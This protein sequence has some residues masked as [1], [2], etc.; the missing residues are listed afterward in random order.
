MEEVN[1]IMQFMQI[2]AQLGPDGQTAI[3]TEKLVDYL[4]DNLGVPMMVRNT[5]A[6]RAVLME[7]AQKQQMQQAIAM[8]QAAMAEQGGAQGAM[9]AGAAA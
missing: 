2:A 8:Q 3:K 7:E 9:P 5:E 1:A 4:A 6:E